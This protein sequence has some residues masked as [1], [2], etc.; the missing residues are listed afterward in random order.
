[1]LTVDLN[2]KLRMRIIPYTTPSHVPDLIVSVAALPRTLSGKIVELAVR[3]VVHNLTV[4]NKAA[5]ANP[6]ALEYFKNIPELQK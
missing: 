2:E 4:K 3:A 6:E 5:L 1:M